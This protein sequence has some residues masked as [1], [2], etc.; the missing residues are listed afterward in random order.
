MHVDH[1]KAVIKYWHNDAAFNN[2][3]LLHFREGVTMKPVAL[4]KNSLILVGLF[5]LYWNEC[6]LVVLAC[7]SLPVCTVCIYCCEHARFCV[8]VFMHHI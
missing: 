2:Y 4:Q 1:L 3:V 6:L 8:E 5:V 7:E